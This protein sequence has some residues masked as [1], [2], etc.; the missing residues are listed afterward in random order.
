MEKKIWLENLKNE[1]ERINNKL[2][3][4]KFWGAIAVE[5]MQ[6]EKSE[7]EQILKKNKI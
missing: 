5:C 2:K 1:L 4:P 3:K 7:I 6:Q